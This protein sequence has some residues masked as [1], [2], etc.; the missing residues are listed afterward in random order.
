MTTTIDD[1]DDPESDDESD[2]DVHHKKGQL[3]KLDEDHRPLL[4]QLRGQSLDE[5]KKIMR[6]YITLSYREFP[7]QM[8]N[9]EAHLTK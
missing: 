3:V 9:E 4:P 2:G 6:E 7:T 5:K 1:Q 8:I